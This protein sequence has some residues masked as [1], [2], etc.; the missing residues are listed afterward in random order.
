MFF[1]VCVFFSIILWKKVAAFFF[2]FAPKQKAGPTRRW[3]K[4]DSPPPPPPPPLDHLQAEGSGA[5]RTSLK[6]SEGQTGFKGSWISVHVYTPCPTKAGANPPNLHNAQGPVYMGYTHRGPPPRLPMRFRP[7]R[8]AHSLFLSLKGK[9]NQLWH[10]VK[11]KAEDRQHRPDLFLKK[12]RKQDRSPTASF[13]LFNSKK[14]K[15]K[16]KKKKR[17]KN[18]LPRM[19]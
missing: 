8:A 4:K 15:K 19:K 6:F 18:R 1:C 13:H 9:V 10:N 11:R 3:M 14:K 7:D 16:K 5:V 2:H 17:K 12:G